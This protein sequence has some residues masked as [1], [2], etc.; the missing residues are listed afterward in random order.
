MKVLS[1]PVLVTVGRLIVSPLMF[2]VLLVY[3]LP[4]DSLF[5]NSI[6][7]FLFVALSLTDF[8][9]SVLV[10]RFGFV[11]KIDKN[12]DKIINKFLFYSTLI[13]LL[14]AGKI[15]F[16]WVIILVGVDFFVL[17][18]RT[19]ARE[20]DFSIPVNFFGKLKINAQ[21][22][23]LSFI[24]INPYQSSGFFNTWNLIEYG[25]LTSV[26]VLCLLSAKSYYDAFKKMYGPIDQIFVQEKSEV[27]EHAW[28]ED[29]PPEP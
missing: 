28:L 13:S 14:A 18:L 20:K 10:S 4:Y 8:V 17:G 23:F 29:R 15:F 21:M 27:K 3:I 11:T 19:V 7:A 16:Y 1:F 12:L 26:L 9:D 5:F 22:I 2:P 25:L 24:I 6:I